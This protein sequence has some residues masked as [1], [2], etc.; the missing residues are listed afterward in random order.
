MAAVPRILHVIAQLSPGGA[1]RAAITVARYSTRRGAYQHSLLSLLPAAPLGAALAREAGL[2]LLDAPLAAE[3]HSAIAGA[4][5]VHLHFW[6]TPELYA[7]LRAPWPA[8]RLILWLHVGGASMPQVVTAEVAAFGD[9]VVAGSA[10]NS[11]LPVLRA[12][13]AAPASLITEPADLEAL[14]GLQPLPHAGFNVG[15]IGTVDFEK[16]NAD[17][18]ALSAAVRVPARFIVCGPGGGYEQ[19][20]RQVQRLGVAERFDFRGYLRDLRAV[21]AELD[22]LGYPLCPDNYSSAELVLREAMFAGVPP[23]VLP[24]GGAARVVTDGVTGVVAADAAGYGAAIERLFHNPLERARLGRNGHDEVASHFTP[25]A[26]A[27]QFDALYA[28]VLQRPKRERAWT[29]AAHSGAE[30]FIEALGEGAGDFITSRSAAE[31]GAAVDACLAAEARIGAASPLLASATSG[32]VLHYRRYFPS[33]AYLRLWAGLVLHG[34]GRHALAVAEFAQ[35]ARLGLDHWRVAWYQAQAAEACGATE[36]AR[37]A[38]DAVL[39]AA[40]LFE[41][42]QALRQRLESTDAR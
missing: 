39:Q 7:L 17:F 36:R 42:A 2:A 37:A 11:E 12:P 30:Q 28:A 13:H 6:N 20:R 35:A 8:A 33:D 32:G 41:P 22:V 5:V 26:A 25:E 23:V 21:L 1:S 14:A 10:Y 4:D 15:Y 24:Y 19:L 31:P 29:G 34:Q 18:I 40:P 9:R 3:V 16:M 27:A 38:A